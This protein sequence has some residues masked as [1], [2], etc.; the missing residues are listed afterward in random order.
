MNHRVLSAAT[1]TKARTTVT[2]VVVALG[3][4]CVNIH[5]YLKDVRS[6]R[7]R[8]ACE[9]LSVSNL[10]AYKPRSP[11]SAGSRLDEGHPR[12]HFTAE[13]QRAAMTIV[14]STNRM[15]LTER[16]RT[17]TAGLVTREKE[18]EGTM[19]AT[20]RNATSLR[21]LCVC[22]ML[23]GA[24]REHSQTLT[25]SAARSES[26]GGGSSSIVIFLPH[27]VSRRRPKTSTDSTAPSARL[28]H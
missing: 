1:G 11:G 9:E 8:R 22:W 13:E 7:P 14:W 19:M 10:V 17:H 25:L 27:R 5:V 6:M 3:T 12:R 24:T 4:P 2:V 20:M 16:A 26:C 21:L 15:S 28:Q 23:R 18:R